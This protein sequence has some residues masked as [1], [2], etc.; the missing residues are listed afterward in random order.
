MLGAT[1]GSEALTFDCWKPILRETATEL[2]QGKLLK[3]V[4]TD[5]RV[6]LV[7]MACFDEDTPPTILIKNIWNE[8]FQIDFVFLSNTKI[9]AH[10]TKIM[11]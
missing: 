9:A 10:A 5:P 2:S 4:F 1:E 11:H 3:D 8:S 7:K 6:S